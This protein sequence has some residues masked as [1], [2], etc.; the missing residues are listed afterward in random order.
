MA[1]AELQ[2]RHRLFEEPFFEEQPFSF[3]QLLGNR[4]NDDEG[5]AASD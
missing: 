5:Y 2:H 4:A 3:A 1:W